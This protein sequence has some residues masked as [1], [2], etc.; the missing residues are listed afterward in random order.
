[1]DFINTAETRQIVA[2]IAIYVACRITDGALHRVG[3]NVVDRLSKT[4]SR[5]KYDREHSQAE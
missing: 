3:A 4:D 5:P 1:M 2:T